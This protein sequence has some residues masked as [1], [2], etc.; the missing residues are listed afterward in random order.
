MFVEPR[1]QRAAYGYVLVWPTEHS[2]KFHSSCLQGK[3][4]FM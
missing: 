1:L 4:Y 2:E 3:R